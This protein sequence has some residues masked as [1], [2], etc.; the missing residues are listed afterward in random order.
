MRCGLQRLRVQI[1]SKSRGSATRVNWA[2]LRVVHA[3]CT[4]SA[5]DGSQRVGLKIERSER[6]KLCGLFDIFCNV[7]VVFVII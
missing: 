2:H 4:R 6:V 5:R 1:A 3:I 7:L